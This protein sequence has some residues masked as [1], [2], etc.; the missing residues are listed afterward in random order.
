MLETSRH[1]VISLRISNEELSQIKTL[2]EESKQST[3]EFLRE[4]LALF[5]SHA[6][7]GQSQGSS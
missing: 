2:R 3:S 4:A 6:K 5:I 7:P 1:Y